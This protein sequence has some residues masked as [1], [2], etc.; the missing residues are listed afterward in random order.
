MAG[1]EVD[2]ELLPRGRV[3][4]ASGG[5][6]LR[7]V[8]AAAVIL[9][10]DL[11]GGLAGGMGVWRFGWHVDV[12]AHLSEGWLRAVPGPLEISATRS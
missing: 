3:A 12:F 5:G 11:R 9:A 7:R 10:T 4:E 6:K 1:K 2:A 8:G